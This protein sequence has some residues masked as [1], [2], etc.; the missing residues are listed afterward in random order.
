MRIFYEQSLI[1]IIP[2]GFLLT[3]FQPS[4]A[5]AD[6]ITPGESRVSYCFKITNIEKYADYSI[7]ALIKSE[8]AGLPQSNKFLKSGSCVDLSGYR[9]YAEIYALK[10]SD[11]NLEE[12]I[13]SKQTGDELKN[14]ESKKAS[15]I[16][17]TKKVYPIRRMKEIY[18]IDKVAKSY[19]I[20]EI[21]DRY[22]KFKNH[23][24]T[25]F[26]KNNKSETKAYSDEDKLPLPSR[27][28]MA[29]LWYIPILGMSLICGAAYWN[30]LNKS[31]K[32]E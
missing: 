1:S 11:I 4:L 12:D 21:N 31:K 22:L 15:L 18:Q 10:K 32:A 9:E 13:I 29:F 27:Q 25:Y 30:K 16:P 28:N 6:V 17:A 26:Y 20:S 14:F 2:L 3:L 24:I 7:L 23:S 19:E 8:N 5:R